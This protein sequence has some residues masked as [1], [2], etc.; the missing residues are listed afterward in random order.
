MENRLRCFLCFIL[1]WVAS[2]SAVSGGY[3]PPKESYLSDYAGRLDDGDGEAIRQMLSTAHR[4]SGVDARVVIIGS[5]A[6]YGTGDQDIES[7]S[8]HLFNSWGIGDAQ[9]NQGIL[10]LLALQDRKVRIELGDGYGA[11]SSQQV[12]R[13]INREIVPRLKQDDVGAAVHAGMRVALADLASWHLPSES[14]ALRP[15]SKAVPR[16]SV[17]PRRSS[18]K[19]SPTGKLLLT[20]LRL[21]GVPI[22]LVAGGFFF[23]RFRKRRCSQ[24]RGVMRRLSEQEEEPS[25][26]AS[27]LQEELLGSVDYDVWHCPQC[28]HA[29][30]IPW[31]RWFSRYDDCPGC[32]SR[33]L[34]KSQTITQAPTVQSTGVLLEM[35]RCSICDY[36]HSNTRELPRVQEV[37]SSSLGLFSGGSSSGGSSSGGGSFSGGSSSG[38]GASGS[39]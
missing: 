38:G 16:P 9:R 28:Q 35:W 4:E 26:S 2:A 1:L 36:D 18:K 8:T 23:L 17:A 39:W 24:C 19:E 3:P 15:P 29:Q 32:G 27:Q 10:L 30:V 22:A 37:D 12:Q 7:F 14:I 25:L 31:R 13:I 33:G 6:E 20:L 21:G 11:K 5:I 34:L